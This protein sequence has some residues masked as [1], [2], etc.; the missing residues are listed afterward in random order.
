MNKAMLDQVR[1][2]ANY[3]CDCCRIPAELDPLPFQPDHIAQQHGGKTVLVKRRKPLIPTPARAGSFLTSVSQ[4]T[5]ILRGSAHLAGSAK[6]QQS[7]FGC[8]AHDPAFS[9]KGARATNATHNRWSLQPLEGRFVAGFFGRV[10][11]IDAWRRRWSGAKYHSSARRLRRFEY[12][13]T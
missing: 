7:I 3:R 2:L 13:T 6:G 4:K 10:R 8:V 5:T 12:E 9:R 11:R 1:E